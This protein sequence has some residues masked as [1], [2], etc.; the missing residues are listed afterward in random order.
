MEN[1]VQQFLDSNMKTKEDLF[2]QI[3]NNKHGVEIG[4]PTP[5]QPMMYKDTASVDNVIFSKHTVWSD[6][7]DEYHYYDNKK[8][9]V[10][11]NDAVDISLVQ[12]D[13]YDFCFSS[14]SL[15]HIA[16]PLKA[17]QE[18]FRIIK[19]GGY[20]VIIVPEKSQCFDHRRDY[21]KFQTLLTQYERNVGE[22]DLSTLPEILEH[23]D[24]EMD[25]PAG[26]KEQFLK[27]SLDNYNNR[28]LHHYV[29]DDE[30]LKQ[31]C[32]CFHGEIV[33]NITEGL[34]RWFI[35]RKT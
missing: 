3:T 32:Y 26:N 8:G 16:N 31:I 9:K 24:L 27:R 28:C 7:T 19:R 10:I 11:I 6:H 23:H 35:M 4:G 5:Q 1:N 12:N 25:R 21:S 17:I 2:Y 18:W 34:D 29:Y 33:Y 13:T 15:E 20:I 22:D 30:L 14:H